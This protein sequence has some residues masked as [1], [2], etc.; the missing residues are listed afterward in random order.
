MNSDVI[1]V[2]AE[3]FDLLRSGKLLKKLKHNR[4]QLKR[5]RASEK[6]AGMRSVRAERAKKFGD[7]DKHERNRRRLLRLQEMRLTGRGLK[8]KGLLNRGYNDVV[9]MDE[10]MADA[11][12][13]DL[14]RSKNLLKRLKRREGTAWKRSFKA[15]RAA[16]TTPRSRVAKRAKK[17]ADRDKYRRT[18]KRLMRLREMQT[19]GR[20]L[21]YKGL[22]NKAF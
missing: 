1:D 16:F 21:K 13:F 15:E 2:D 9:D 22:W 3:N 10:I 19:T 12:N 11:A 17:F 8:S 18:A 4:K 20:G 7:R 5:L 14:M 6:A